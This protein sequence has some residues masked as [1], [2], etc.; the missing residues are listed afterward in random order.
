MPD[1]KTPTPDAPSLI[2]TPPE[3]RIKVELE[4]NMAKMGLLIKAVAPTLM[5]E[6]VLLDAVGLVDDLDLKDARLPADGICRVVIDYDMTSDLL[7]MST[8]VPRAVVKG[9]IAH[10]LGSITRNQ[11]QQNLQVKLAALEQ[12]IAELEARIGVP[13]LVLPS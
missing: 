7:T 9:I 11:M 12:R 3:G 1:N 13:R 5:I 6:A 4:F 8:Q 10:A 2:N